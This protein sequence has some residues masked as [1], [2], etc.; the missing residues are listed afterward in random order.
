MGLREMRNGSGHAAHTAVLGV[1]LVALLITATLLSRTMRATDRINAKAAT[2]A[3][4]GRGINTAT[5]SIIQLRRTNQTASS[6]LNSTK[7]LQGELAQ[8]VE[9]AKAVDGLSGSID[10]HTGAIN[11]TVGQLLATAGAISKT[12]GD[13][14]TTTKKLAASSATV[15]ES[16]KKI[17]GT[18][19]AIAT[20]AKGINGAVASLLDVT[21]KIEHDVVLINQRLDTGLDL[22]RALKADTGN[23]LA[24]VGVTRHQ[25]ACIDRKVAGSGAD[26]HC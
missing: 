11:A 19:A 18:T 20:T 6:I 7:P 23:L 8:M 17:G 25:A 1:V 22:D 3:K 14:N 15:N 21:K 16:A 24:E 4:T 9:L 13:V 10:T 5:D 26:N 12:A 2:I